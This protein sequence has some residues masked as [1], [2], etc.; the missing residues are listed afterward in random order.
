MD[1]STVIRL[2]STR[3]KATVDIYRSKKKEGAYVFIEQGKALDELPDALLKQCGVL[4]FSLTM[5]LTPDKKLANANARNVLAALKANG[6]YLQL[7]PQLEAYMQ[8]VPND[9][10]PNQ[11]I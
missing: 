6:F 3:M 1:D 7:P 8:K 4:E 2:E 5:E 11:P 10:L 9:K